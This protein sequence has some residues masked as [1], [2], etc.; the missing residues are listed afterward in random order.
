QPDDDGAEKSSGDLGDYVHRYSRPVES[1]DGS[2]RDRHGGI[3]VRAADAIH[4]VDG[5]GDGERPPGGD[6]DP[7]RVVSFGALQHDVGDDAVAEH[8]QD[9]GTK[10]LSEDR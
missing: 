4:A 6:D 5:D 1:A 10:Y 9:G 7:T 3:Q 8:D 2:K